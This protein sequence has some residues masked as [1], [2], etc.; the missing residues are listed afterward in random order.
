MLTYCS[1]ISDHKEAQ[2]MFDIN[3]V[4][5]QTTSPAPSSWILYIHILCKIALV[6]DPSTYSS[7]AFRQLTRRFAGSQ[8]APK[9]DIFLVTRDTDWPFL[10]VFFFKIR[11][12]DSIDSILLILERISLRF[13][14]YDR[15]CSKRS[16]YRSRSHHGIKLMPIWWFQWLGADSHPNQRQ[17]S[18]NLFPIAWS[19]RMFV[20]FAQ[21]RNQKLPNLQC[22]RWKHQVQAWILG[23]FDGWSLWQTRL[24]P[25]KPG[26]SILIKL[27]Q[28]RLIIF[29]LVGWLFLQK[30]PLWSQEFV[31]TSI[32]L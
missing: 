9:L 14:S 25:Q 2:D 4:L 11:Q 20:Q 8:L 15:Y 30:E 1:V 7:T 5:L 31:M 13:D 21:G 23:M 16:F 19:Q 26:L 22:D 10:S 6:Q 12:L 29:L 3:F 24:D 28:R 27:W 32:L 17:Q 18:H